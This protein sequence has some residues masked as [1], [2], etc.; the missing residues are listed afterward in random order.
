[1]LLADMATVEK[2]LDKV[3]R[4]A[5]GQKDE[6]EE[7]HV[8]EELLPALE[9]GVPVRALPLNNTTRNFI[10]E[11]F[12]LTT[13][14]AIYLAN[15]GAPD[16]ADENKTAR[17]V[18]AAAERDGAVALDVY[19]GLESEL[20]ELPEEEAKAFREELDIGRSGRKTVLKTAAGLLD[21]VTFYTVENEIVS[22]FRVPG[23]TPAKTAAG[24]IHSDLAEK[25]IRAEIVSYA[26]LIELGSIQAARDRGLIR[27][28][29]PAYVV[30][31]GDIM[32][33][34]H[35]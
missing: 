27:T 18:E 12:L 23:G 11:L 20:M 7:V 3:R 33:V 21:L 22:A 34:K 30:Q 26:D 8:L 25:F 32:K 5:K 6:S 19:C 1:L 31:D 29:G 15:R 16:D 13:K 28:E 4:K 14:P 2:R 17:A 9:E 24:K 10:S 35:G